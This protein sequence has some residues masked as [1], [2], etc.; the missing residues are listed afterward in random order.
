[1]SERLKIARTLFSMYEMAFFD[2]HRCSPGFQCCPLMLAAV[3]LPPL[4]RLELGLS[5]AVVIAA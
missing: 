4:D 5:A 3:I 1:M 2:A